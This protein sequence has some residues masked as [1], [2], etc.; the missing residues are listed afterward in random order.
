MTLKP[1]YTI[2]LEIQGQLPLA[3]GNS[4]FLNIYLFIRR[5]GTSGITYKHVDGIDYRQNGNFMQ[6]KIDYLCIPD[7][8]YDFVCHI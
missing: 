5:A 3:T 8:R 4:S 1:S 7:Y 2:C 6:K